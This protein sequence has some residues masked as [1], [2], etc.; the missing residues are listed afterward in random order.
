MQLE[1]KKWFQRGVVLL[2]V[3]LSIICFLTIRPFIPT[4]EIAAQFAFSGLII[5]AL[6]G[7]TALLR[8]LLP[9]ILIKFLPKLDR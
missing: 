1:Q 8:L 2:S 5:G 6:A 9:L 7:F 3:S 4:S